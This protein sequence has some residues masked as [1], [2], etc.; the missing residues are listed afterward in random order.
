MKSISKS[1]MLLSMALFL[2]GVVIRAADVDVRG[3][4]DKLS[5]LLD[6][7]DPGMKRLRD[8]DFSKIEQVYDKLVQTQNILEKMPEGSVPGARYD[9]AWRY[10]DLANYYA[11]M[12]NFV[13]AKEILDSDESGKLQWK[14]LKAPQATLNAINFK[15]QSDELL[16]KK[17]EY[18]RKLIDKP[19]SEKAQGML[20]EIRG[21]KDIGNILNAGDSQTL[22]LQWLRLGNLYAEQ[23]NLAKAQ[24]L[25]GQGE[26]QLAAKKF[27]NLNSRM[28]D[29]LAGTFK[30]ALSK[31]KPEKPLDPL[32]PIDVTQPIKPG[33]TVKP[34]DSREPVKPLEPGKLTPGGQGGDS[35]ALRDA[36]QNLANALNGVQVNL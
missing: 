13:R 1:V 20:D 36:L 29:V 9:A 23:G 15:K 35:S 33:E 32:K 2:F 14:K 31:E 30:E 18:L 22:F 6:E 27:N 7:I 17:I 25:F 4:E 3:L 24:E 19:D 28:S 12:G 11:S 10:R 5:A 34:I 26:G 16:G 21:I 8:E